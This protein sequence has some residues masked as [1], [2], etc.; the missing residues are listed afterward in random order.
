[1]VTYS[2]NSYFFIYNFFQL[3]GIHNNIIREHG[4]HPRPLKS[5]S[6]TKEQY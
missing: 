1:M 3:L 2:V 4:Q 6:N 5:A